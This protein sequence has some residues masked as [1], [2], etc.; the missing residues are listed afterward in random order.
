MLGVFTVGFA[1]LMAKQFY[2]GDEIKMA[3]FYALRHK[4]PCVTVKR[5]EHLFS[6][7]PENIEDLLKQEE[8]YEAFMSLEKMLIER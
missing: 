1:E 2:F 6:Y 5:G 7:E 8:M 4:K 3:V